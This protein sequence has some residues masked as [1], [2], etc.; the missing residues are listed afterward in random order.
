M[1][2]KTRIVPEDTGYCMIWA[3]RTS[4]IQVLAEIG[5][6]REPKAG[7]YRAK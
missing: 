2:E 6:L 7:D 1:S 5:K 3:R 4:W